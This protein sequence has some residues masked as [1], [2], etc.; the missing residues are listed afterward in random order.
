[1]DPKPGGER[2][3]FHSVFIFAS[4]LVGLVILH[5]SLLRLPY[6][7]DEAGYYVPAAHDLLESGSLIPYSTPSNAHPP[8]VMAYLAVCWKI[9]G[10]APVVTRMSMLGLAAFSL[11]GLFRLARRVANTKV[12]IASVFCTALYPVF[13]SQ[14]SLAQVDLTVAGLTFWALLAYV[15][16][17]PWLTTLWFS[18]AVLAKETAILAPATLCLF[19]L[20]ETFLLIRKSWDADFKVGDLN[21]ILRNRLSR[22]WVLALPLLPLLCWYAYHRL[23]TGFT[24]GNPEFFR[25]NVQATMHPLRI[26]LALI[27]RIWQVTGYMNLYV[28]TFVAIAAMW[29]SPRLSSSANGA[30]TNAQNR[31]P[32]IELRTQFVFLSLIAVYALA[33]AVIGGAVLARYMLPV[34]PLEM[35]ICVS[36]LWRRVPIWYGVIGLVLAAFAVGLFVNP[37]YGFSFEDNLAYRDFVIIHQHAE[38]LLQ[39]RY[40]TARVLTAWPATGEITQT[41]L[42]YVNRPMQVL[43]IDNFTVDELAAASAMRSRFDVALVFSTK[44]QPPHPLLENWAAW[45]KLKSEY[46]GYHQDL[47]PLEAARVL[48]GQV[49]YS[50]NRN[51]QWIAVIDTQSVQSASIAE[52]RENRLARH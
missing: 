41:R 1:L 7:W 20:V 11:L 22:V 2:T 14:S 10:Y 28:L 38:A 23:R 50:E 42:G 31:R 26:L 45:G 12:A 16:D 34:V 15:E 36:T 18:L 48:G 21:A 4:L 29:L 40:P 39:E 51:G 35:I 33:M 19:E 44:Y 46:F 43:P 25:Y 37:P 47:H 30:K 24:F 27:M 32:R 3:R 6:F 17:R 9:A 8:L 5:I 52:P 49:V 13:F